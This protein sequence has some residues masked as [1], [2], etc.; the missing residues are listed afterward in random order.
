MV[1]LEALL[2]QSC[3]RLRMTYLLKLPFNNI[4]Y[5]PNNNFKSNI[6]LK[7]TQNKLIVLLVGLAYENKYTRI[8]L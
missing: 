6:I 1:I 7:M 8:Q 3:I 5:E 4:N 2:C